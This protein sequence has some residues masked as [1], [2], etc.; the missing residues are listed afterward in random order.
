[1]KRNIILAI[2]A[3]FFS[4]NIFAQFEDNT[5]RTLAIEAF[6]FRGYDI[7]NIKGVRFGLFPRT[8][9]LLAMAGVSFK[10]Y[11]DSSWDFK[12]NMYLMTNRNQ[13][14]AN[15]LLGFKAASQIGGITLDVI[16][17]TTANIGA[18]HADV[19]GGLRISKEFDQHFI[20]SA[21][22]EYSYDIDSW[23][24]GV[25]NGVSLSIFFGE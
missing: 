25:N 22:S 13:A 23:K 5:N 2:I 19:A 7:K 1:M 15:L 18:K 20:I 16:P 17:Y 11:T 9:P 6:I 4:V 10:N 21:F 3:I 14:S 12:Q 8:V 24:H